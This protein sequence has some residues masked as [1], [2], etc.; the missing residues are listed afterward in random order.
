[1]R[2]ALIR[3]CSKSPRGPLER[4]NRART[5]RQTIQGYWSP[6]LNY[7]PPKE[8]IH[9][10][11][12]FSSRFQRTDESAELDA[13]REWAALIGVPEYVQRIKLNPPQ[14]ANKVRAE[15]RAYGQ[16]DF[17][18]EMRNQGI[19]LIP[20]PEV[21]DSDAK[22]EAWQERTL[23]L[24]TEYEKKEAARMKQVKLD[25]K[26]LKIQLRQERIHQAWRD[27]II[28]KAKYPWANKRPDILYGEF[29]VRTLDGTANANEPLKFATRPN[30]V[31]EHTLAA[32]AAFKE[33]FKGREKITIPKS[34]SDAASTQAAAAAS[35]ILKTVDTSTSQSK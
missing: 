31:Y 13:A 29:P 26:E 6:L 23:K 17:L 1:V 12:E 8:R 10:D 21:R 22:F 20:P 32:I 2:D 5:N 33:K 7:E 27:S 19:D 25:K 15:K 4:W 28:V 11:D 35:A 34:P 30:P 14:L 9:K 24:L 3:L 16:L 18:Q